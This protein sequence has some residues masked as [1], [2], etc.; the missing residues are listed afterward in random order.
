MTEETMQQQPEQENTD[1]P[2][3]AISQKAEEADNSSETIRRLGERIS[4][5]EGELLRMEQQAQQQKIRM[6][7]L[8]CL[9]QRGIPEEAVE[10]VMPQADTVL[11]EEDILPRIE[12]LAKAVEKAA[13]RLLEERAGRMIPRTG[14]QTLLTGAF[15]RETPVARLA[16]MMGK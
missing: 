1:S 6:Q 2:V 5:L 13:V 7:C 12:L 8:Q 16:E 10:L 11:G 14:T 3:E 15:I 9:Q 4:E